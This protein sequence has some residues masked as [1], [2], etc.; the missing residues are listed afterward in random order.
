MPYAAVD[1]AH[2]AWARHRVARARRQSLPVKSVPVVALGGLCVFAHDLHE[3]YRVE[4]MTIV[5][6]RLLYRYVPYPPPAHDRPRRFRCGAGSSGAQCAIGRRGSVVALAAKQVVHQPR[7]PVRGS[8]TPPSR[9]P[10]ARR[11]RG[12]NR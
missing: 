11:E 1:A 12:V 4:L 10:P 8:Y 6:V 9:E 3:H 7:A 2:F 5:S